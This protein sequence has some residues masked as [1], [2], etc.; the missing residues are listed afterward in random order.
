MEELSNKNL[1]KVILV[2]HG[3]ALAYIIAWWMNFDLA[4]L[5][6]SYFSASPASVSHLITNIYKQ[7]VLKLLNCTK[8]LNRISK[9]VN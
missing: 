3:C 5:E 9:G 6:K 8:H 2:T 7:R 4:L 1:G